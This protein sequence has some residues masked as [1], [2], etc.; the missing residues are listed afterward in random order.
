MDNYPLFSYLFSSP[1]VQ[2]NEERGYSEVDFLDYPTE[3]RALKSIM[4]KKAG[5]HIRWK[6]EVAN[7]NNFLN[8]Y[9]N[10]KIL[11]FTGHGENG[12]VAFENEYGVLDFVSQEQLSEMLRAGHIQKPECVFLSACYA[13]TVADA[14][15]NV[16]VQ[17][18]ITVINDRILDKASLDFTDSFYSALLGGKSVSESF[19]L[20]IA[21]L[22]AQHPTESVKF[23]LKGHGNHD[24]P[25]FPF[26][27]HSITNALIDITPSLPTSQCHSP[28]MFSIGRQCEVHQVY[29]LL[30]NDMKLVN[31]TGQKGIGKTEVALRVA[32]Y[33]RER[34]SFSRLLFLEL[35]NA[36][37]C[38]EIACLE[39]LVASFCTNTSESISSLICRNDIEAVVEY[40]RGSIAQDEKVL[41]L[42]D[43]I[44]AWIKKK[45]D[46]LLALVSRM[47]QRLGESV[48]IVLTS[49]KNID[50][51][52]CREVVI[53][54]LSDIHTAKLFCM[55]APRNLDRDELT[56]EA[57]ES[58]SDP[59]QAFSKTKLL[60][61]MKV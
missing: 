43:G 42:M 4:E 47:R 57:N 49:Q 61:S 51:D 23:E 22:V 59:I 15:V 34:Y 53:N 36:G 40:I 19:N 29:N 38:S 31:I 60:H 50:M 27:D 12:V 5:I 6:S 30:I 39:K 37:D 55:R 48:W 28:A 44:D 1:L 41:L 26:T 10:S 21:R 45:R 13:Q 2:R 35:S 24:E 54:S 11:H 33:S 56:L 20:G 16:G 17:H 9:S 3:R 25:I 18:V 58:H 8:A 7:I 46:F 52:A 32:E 14:F